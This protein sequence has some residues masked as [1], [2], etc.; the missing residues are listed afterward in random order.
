MKYIPVFI[1][2][3]LKSLWKNRKAA[4][5]LWLTPIFFLLGIG[6]IASQLLKAESPIEPFKVA[7]VN[8]DPTLETKLVI[9]QLTESEHLNRIIQTSDMD[10]NV[11]EKLMGENELV[12]AIYIPKGFSKDIARGSY[13][14]VKVVGNSN[15][16]LESQ[17]VRH[18][19]ESAADFTSSA[20]SGINTVDYFMDEVPNFSK[21]EKSTQFK[22][23]IVSYSLHVIGRGEIFEEKKFA[24]LYQQNF[25]HYYLI[26]FYILLLM[27]WSF[28]GSLLIRM[29]EKRS[30]S[31]RLIGLGISEFQMTSARLISTVILVLASCLLIMVPILFY[32][33]FKQSHFVDLLII[34]LVSALVFSTF[35]TMLEAIVKDKKIQLFIGMGSILLGA[36]LGEH[37]IP[38]V[39]YPEW[40]EQ[41]NLIAINGWV[42]KFSFTLF[43]SGTGPTLQAAGSVLFL[44]I[45]FQ[46]V[47]TAFINNRKG[48]ET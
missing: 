19:M 34:T 12:A 6:I 3:Y 39:F 28:L 11:A 32:Y 26:S 8:E 40:L 20:R 46:M 30:T 1:A 23:D 47:L 36:I 4:T 7:I 24:S 10:K 43:E 2:L 48:R 5:L 41:L 33:G 37:L 13:N 44:I 15:R 42:L 21:S 27:S 9:R 16:P 18:V 38:V 45:T 17:L 35:F 22:R 29:N 31:L 25:L 14:P